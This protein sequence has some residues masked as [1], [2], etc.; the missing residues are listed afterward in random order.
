[1]SIFINLILIRSTTGSGQSVVSLPEN[2]ESVLTQEIYNGNE[3]DSRDDSDS[4]DD[5]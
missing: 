1:M 4:E 2:T 5:I 3:V